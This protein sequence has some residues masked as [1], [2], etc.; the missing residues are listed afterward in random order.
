[1]AQEI[2]NLDQFEK[3]L[4]DAGNAL[5]CVDFTAKWYIIILV[6]IISCRFLDEP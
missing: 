6:T 3:A 2:K 1:M 5:V 4:K